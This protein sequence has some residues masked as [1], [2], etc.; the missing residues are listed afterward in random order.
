MARSIVLL[1]GGLDSTV[2]LTRAV[3]ET[4]VVTVLY[5]DFGQK[6]AKRELAAVRKIVAKFGVKSRVISLPWLETITRT[7]LVDMSAPIPE[8]ENFDELDI[9]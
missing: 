8:V 7:G 2:N 1:S 5:F 3:S 4:E 6:A 9:P